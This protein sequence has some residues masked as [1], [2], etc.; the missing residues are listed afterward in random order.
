MKSNNSNLFFS[1]LIFLIL[2]VIS[3]C[4]TKSKTVTN[5]PLAVDFNLNTEKTLTAVLEQAAAEN[6]LV[7][8]DF[9]ADW[10]LPCQL[11]DEEVFNKAEVYNLMNKHFVN[12]KVDIEKSNGANLKLMFNASGLPTLLFLDSKGKVLKRRDETIFQ[13]ELVSIAQSLIKK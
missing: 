4:S 6:K 10:C 2:L 7:F 12:Y 1:V 5:K 11:M 8:V 9:Y 3:S 13:T